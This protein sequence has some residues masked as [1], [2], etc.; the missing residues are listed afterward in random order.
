[1]EEAI[2]KAP[3]MWAD[4]HADVKAAMDAGIAADGPAEP[5]RW[6]SGGS[7]L[8][9]PSPAATRASSSRSGSMYQNEPKVAGMD[10]AAM[11][12]GMDWIEK[13]A[14]RRGDQAPGA[15]SF[16]SWIVDRRRSGLG[17]TSEASSLLPL[18]NIDY[19]LSAILIRCA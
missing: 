10:T 19:P 8:S 4:L 15:V 2:Q 17:N 5:R 9:A 18:S 14:S 16:R 1:M 7:T 12:P 13:A 6:P 3:Q 11:K